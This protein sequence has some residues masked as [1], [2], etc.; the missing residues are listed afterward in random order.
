ML[1]IFFI[2][3]AKE[4]RKS[5]ILTEGI[6]G[7]MI[8]KIMNTLFNRFSATSFDRHRYKTLANSVVV[9]VATSYDLLS[10]NKRAHY[11]V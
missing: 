11:C 9:S 6:S 5:V 4:S 3:F 10:G 1:L 8:K 7:N 2:D